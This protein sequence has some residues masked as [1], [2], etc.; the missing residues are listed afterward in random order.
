MAVLP[1][2][3]LPVELV[4]ADGALELVEELVGVFQQHRSLLVEVVDD[5]ALL[6]HFLGK[7]FFFLPLVCKQLFILECNVL[8]ISNQ[9]S[10]TLQLLFDLLLLLLDNINGPKCFVYLFF[11]EHYLV[12]KCCYFWLFGCKAHLLILYLILFFHLSIFHQLCLLFHFVYLKLLKLDLI[13]NQLFLSYF[14]ALELVFQRCNFCLVSHVLFNYLR[15]V[16]IK[17]GISKQ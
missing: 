17:T 11:G 2:K 16:C 7:L 15:P 14:L 4:P 5:L 6:H 13:C 12:V 8:N 10:F 3:G 9:L 1:S